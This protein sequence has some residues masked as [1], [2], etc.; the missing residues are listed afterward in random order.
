MPQRKT[1]TDS[2]R[3]DIHHETKMFSLFF[4]LLLKKKNHSLVLAYTL[5]EVEVRALFKLGRRD[6]KERW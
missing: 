1:R 6:G 4:L 5:G 2:R 3:S